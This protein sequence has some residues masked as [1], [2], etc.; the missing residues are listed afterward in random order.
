MS[1]FNS[2]A[3]LAAPLNAANIDTDQM[4]PG[5]FLMKPR[6]FDYGSLLF[7]DLRFGARRDPNFVLNQPRYEKAE[8]L[9]GGENFGCG[10]A[11]EQAAYALLQYGI[12]AVFAPS[13]GDIFKRNCLNNGLLLGTIDSSA[14]AA[15]CEAIRSR[16]GAHLSIDLSTQTIATEDG[17]VV[18]F[19]ISDGD[20]RKLISGLDDVDLTR[21]QQPEIDAFENRLSSDPSWLV[22]P[23]GWDA[24][25]DL[26]AGTAKTDGESNV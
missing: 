2:I 25:R 5:R 20:K 18:Q 15:L 21:S 13:F 7:H 11:R 26:R 4:I 23:L 16:Q 1:G 14:A 24:L 8:I 17:L 22:K 6:D 10:S 9:I 12:K 3:G 19:G